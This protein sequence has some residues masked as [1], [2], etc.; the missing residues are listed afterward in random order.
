MEEFVDQVSDIV[1]Y[2][3]LNIYNNNVEWSGVLV[4]YDAEFFYTVGE[5]NGVYITGRYD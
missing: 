4:K 3:P 1:D 5:R 2:G